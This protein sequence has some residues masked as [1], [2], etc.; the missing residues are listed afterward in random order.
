MD[1]FFIFG[2]VFFKRT[3]FLVDVCITYPWILLI[4]NT[5]FPLKFVLLTPQ[6]VLTLETYIVRLKVAVLVFNVE[7]LDASNI[8]F[9]KH[10]H[11]LLHYTFVH[12]ML[13]AV[14][15]IHHIGQLVLRS[16]HLFNS[17]LQ[18]L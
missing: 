16:H 2:I 9:M 17:Q 11:L 13:A 18:L 15:F 10:I 5:L 3:S 1:G 8:V 12:L 7:L 14:P 4:L 6:A